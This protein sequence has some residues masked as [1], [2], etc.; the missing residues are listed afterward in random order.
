[1]E[2]VL[3][4]ATIFKC[5][6]FGKYSSCVGQGE[7]LLHACISSFRL[8]AAFRVFSALPVPCIP[9]PMKVARGR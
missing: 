3:K 8:V 6:M 1:M 4:M 5:F 7:G 9:K 2:M